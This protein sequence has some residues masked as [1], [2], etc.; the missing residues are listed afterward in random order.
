[1]AFFALSACATG[2]KSA[3]LPQSIDEYTRITETVP[4]TASAYNKRGIYYMDIRYYQ[5][6][7][8]N[9]TEAIRIDQ[10]FADARYNRGLA[11]LKL[12]YAHMAYQDLL[13]A[14]DLERDSRDR[15]TQYSGST[16][17]ETP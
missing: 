1:M 17:F 8:E 15:R 12:N 10:R 5:K 6:A 14:S 2:N 7:V 4:E 9:F 3:G 16:F 11:Y 13:D